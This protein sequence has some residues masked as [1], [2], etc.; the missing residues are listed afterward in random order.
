MRNQAAIG[1]LGGGNVRSALQQQAAGFAQQ[2]LQN[3]ISRLG[4]VAGQGQQA[5]QN[6]AGLGAQTAGQIAQLTGQAGQAQAS[7][8]LGAQ[9]ARQQRASGILG[10]GAALLSDENMKQNIQDMTPEDCMRTVLNLDIK[11]WEYLPQLDLG[12]NIHIGPIAQDAPKCIK[13]DGK[14]MLDLHSELML[15]AGAMQ[16]LKQEGL[17]QCH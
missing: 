7:G 14:E 4:S 16:Y 8:I 5:Q 15:I 9:Q 17:I 1:G 11:A 6:I 3:Q 10:A 13:V 12:E 2:D